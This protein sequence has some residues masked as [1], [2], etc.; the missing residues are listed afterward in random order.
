ML[1]QT[2]RRRPPPRRP[3]ANTG[4]TANAAARAAPPPPSPDRFRIKLGKEAVKLALNGN[5][6]RAA[7]VNRAILELHPQDSEAA[8]RLAK[9]LME[10][11]D[12]A[13]A[14]AVL[15]DL[16]RRDPRNAIA[17]KNRARLEN[18]AASAGT[19][20][21]DADASAPTPATATPSP[22]GV[23]GA[24]ALF[25]QDG[26]KSGTAIL[27]PVAP[28]PVPF[29]DDY[30]PPTTARAAA[31]SPGDPA[32]LSIV[33]ADA[34]A[35][36]GAGEAVFVK[37][38]DGGILGALEP[39]MAR[40]LRRLIAGGNRYS[41]AVVGIAGARIS[42]IIRETHCAPALRNV[43]SFPAAARTPA[44]HADAYGDDDGDTDTAVAA[45]IRPETPAGSPPE[46]ASEPDADSADGDPETIAAA[47]VS[48]HLDDDDADAAAD[49]DDD[50]VPMLDDD[51]AADHALPAFIAPVADD[52]E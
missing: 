49:T 23:A 9:A 46:T 14:R 47:L 50:A 25:I 3:D 7:A 30:A 22:A 27:R 4:A 32:T 2:A 35:N 6:P 52:W 37:A 26:G 28:A 15:D 1:P 18:L 19:V 48:D 11:G 12:Y 17:R 41:A 5:W 38:A 40:R 8:N 21:T 16:C 10:L 34:D 20:K 31:V 29:S 44:I 42:V 36:A 39:R 43:V 45:G 13:G 33:D 24:P 51:A